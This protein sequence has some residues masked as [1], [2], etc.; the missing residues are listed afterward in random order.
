MRPPLFFKQKDVFARQ[1]RRWTRPQLDQALRRIAEAAKA[2]RLSS[3]IEDIL[4]ERL[5]LSLSLMATAASSAS[6]SR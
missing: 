3:V 6:A 2:A 4:A 5:I 1:V